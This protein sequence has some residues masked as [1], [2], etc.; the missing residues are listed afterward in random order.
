MLENYEE[1]AE[2]S[3]QKYAERDAAERFLLFDAVKERR[4]EKVLDLGCGAGQEL[5]PFLEK[6]EAFC[7][8]VDIAP[9][10][11]KVTKTNFAEKEKAAF[12]RSTGEKLSFAD[13]SFDVVLCRVALPYMDNCKTV[14]EVARILKPNGVF[15]LKTH[16]PPFFFAMLKE[17]LKTFNPKQIAYPLI[18]LAGSFWHLL[19]GKQLQKGFWRGKEIFQTQGF[20][21]K[22]CAANGLKIEGFLADNNLQTPS[23]LIVKVETENFI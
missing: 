12:V 23:Y 1:Y 13:E 17:R 8:G 20:I 3:L 4:L 6:S 10:L 14:S 21:E 18:C 16:A 15:L 11:G 19:T 7:V 2:K 5:L 22:E 9:E